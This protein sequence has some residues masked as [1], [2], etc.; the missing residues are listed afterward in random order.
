MGGMGEDG[1]TEI[2]LVQRWPYQK[3]GSVKPDSI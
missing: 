3:C 2:V 1:L